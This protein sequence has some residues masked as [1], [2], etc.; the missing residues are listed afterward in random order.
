MINNDS[1][2]EDNLLEKLQNNKVKPHG[3]GIG[4]LNIHKRLQLIFGADYGLEL[5]NADDNHA[6]AQINIP[7]RQL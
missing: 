3:F 2:F 5:Y 7:G 4:L 6:V 1:Q